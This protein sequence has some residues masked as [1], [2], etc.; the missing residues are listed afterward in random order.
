MARL[1]LAV[2]PPA[3]IIEQLRLVRRKD[4]RGVRFIR[5]DN[6]HVTLRFLGDVEPDDVVECVRHAEL[7]PATGRVGPS[8]DVLGSHSIVAP[9]AG[10]ERLA[11]ALEKATRELGRP[12]DHPDFFGHITLA[13]VKRGAIVRHVVGELVHGEFDVEEVALVES[14]LRPEGSIYETLATWPVRG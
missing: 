1:F 8:I 5:P 11:D 9:V 10:L 12:L 13:K 7:P 2:W 4:Q 14:R 3:E 6:W